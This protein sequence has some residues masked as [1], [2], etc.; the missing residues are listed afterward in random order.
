M[1]V[2][3]LL[4][5]SSIMYGAVI[6]NRAFVIGTNAFVVPIETYWYPDMRIAVFQTYVCMYP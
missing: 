6:I 5:L 3:T 1:T 4:H 2:E